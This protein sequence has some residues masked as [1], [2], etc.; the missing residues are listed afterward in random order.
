LINLD[1]FRNDPR[2]YDIRGKGLSSVILD[3]G[4]DRNH[5]F[6]GADLNSDGISD[7]IVYQFDFANNDNNASD[8]DGHGSN[9]SSIAGSSSSQYPGIAPEVN[10]IHLKVFTDSGSGN[11]G[12]VERALQW[13]VANVSNFN[14]VSVNM[15]LGDSSNRSSRTS[16]YGLGDELAALAA[17]GVI[18][19]SASGNDFFQ[20]GSSQGVSY[21]AADPNSLSVG[22]VYDSNV[23]GFSY[24][25]GAVAN[26]SGPG[27]VTPFSQRHSTLT[28][29]LAP[30]APITGANQNGGT[31]TQHGTS[32]ASPH[33]SGVAVLAQEL[34]LSVLNR[35]LSPNEFRNI[36]RS[37]ANTIVDGDDE[38]DNV[39]NTNLSFP[40]VDMMA[41]GESIWAMGGVPAASA[42]VDDLTMAE[43]SPHYFEVSFRDSDSIDV[44]TINGSDVRV[45]GPN[46]YS[47]LGKVVS[48]TPRQNSKEIVVIYS[49]SGADGTWGASG[50]GFYTLEMQSNEVKD[51][52]GNSVPAG[53]LAS[54]EVAIAPDLGPSMGGYWSS[55][56]P[57]V[58]TDITSDGILVLSNVDDGAIEITPFDFAFTFHGTTYNSVFVS[59]NGLIS[60][61][62]SNSDYINSNLSSTP[63]LP[64]V[65]VYW[66]DLFADSPNLGLFWKLIGTGDRQQLVLQWETEIYGDN[67]RLS[68]QAVLNE[69]DGSIR[70]SYRDLIGTASGPGSS[71]TI[72]LKDADSGSQLLVSFNGIGNP[73]ARNGRSFDFFPGN[74]APSDIELSQSSVREIGIGVVAT[75]IA[76]QD[77]DLADT[78][79][80]ALVSGSGD[81]DNGMFAIDNGRL[82]SNVAIDYETKP[83]LSIRIRAIDAGGLFVERQFTIDV[84]DVPEMVVSPIVGDGSV[85]RSLVNQVLLRFDGDIEIDQG[86]FRVI[87]RG[88]GGGEVVVNHSKTIENSGQA[89]VTLT[90][91]GSFTRGVN[92]VLNDG[93]YE[94]VIDGVKVRRNGR[95][96]DSN[97]DGIE[98]D[99]SRFGNREEDRFFALFGDSNGNGIV[100]AIDSLRFRNLLNQPV[101]APKVDGIFD[102]NG[103]S[104]ID[105]IDALRF[106]N[107]LNKRLIWE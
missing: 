7:R 35:R 76:V 100:D 97:A 96:L 74:R 90:F 46:G 79:T 45:T 93:F 29:I 101:V 68:F 31:V 20:F 95:S 99:V 41:L 62:S 78:H 72:G 23:G 5:P 37:T 26:T 15:S 1:D 13:V 88:I 49:A 83:R 52:S 98:G 10:L 54:F 21:P 55:A 53:A 66:D 104:F 77:P 51:T 16:L 58:F 36:L 56:V 85:Q 2:F 71:A 47:A 17:L 44:T 73:Y 19:A 50:N 103:N 24:Q 40:L 75:T 33:I 63:A 69:Y 102:F 106:R 60:F 57:F 61:G 32:Q 27:R 25:S 9:V 39:V 43:Q 18:V 89:V 30:G 48:I 92:G 84:L 38:D 14:I 8:F 42:K 70:V 94:L 65:A 107:N 4:I 22:A 59:S 105:A 6:F 91:S 67:N 11:F 82:I 81:L 28:D 87:R 12:Y 34:A 3:T 64:I 86:A 80:M